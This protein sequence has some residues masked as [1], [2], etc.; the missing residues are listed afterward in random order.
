MTDG[1]APFSKTFELVVV[2]HGQTQW[3]RALRFQ[4]HTDVSLDETGRSQALALG[5]YLSTFT[6]ARAVSSDLS[7][8][9]ETAELILGDRGPRLELDPRWREMQ[10]GTWEGLTWSEIVAQNPELAHRPANTP[11]FYTPPNGESF[12]ALCERVRGAVGALDAGARDGTVALV[13]TH[14]GAL[15][16]LLRVLLGESEAAALS[17]RF[18]PATITRFG[19]APDGARIIELNRSV[20]ESVA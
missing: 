17:V 15:H 5:A 18:L 6:F 13:V 7:R 14:A 20:T 3:N 8:A 12:D 10:F 19:I 9:R 1:A 4:G 2:R 16:A 11:R